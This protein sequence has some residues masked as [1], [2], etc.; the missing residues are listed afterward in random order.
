MTRQTN[1]FIGL[2]LVAAIAA[3][4]AVH[5]RTPM[6]LAGRV[7]DPVPVPVPPALP[8]ELTL[9]IVTWPGFALPYVA[10]E[11]NLFRNVTVNVRLLDDI[12]ARHAAFQSGEIDLMIGSVDGFTQEY[13]QGIHGAI[14]LVTDESAGADAILGNKAV[15]DVKALRGRRVAFARATP[16]HYL[17]YKSLTANGLTPADIRQFKVDDPTQAGQALL[18]GSV[19]AAATWEP[20]LSELVQSGKG[21]VLAS[22]KDYPGS[23]V[24]IVVASPSAQ[25]DEASLQAFV[26][27]WYRA[28]DF[29]ASN[30][31]EG[32]RI[33][34]SGLGLKP[35]EAQQLLLGLRLA[36]RSRN[37]YFMCSA[38]PPPIA[39]IIRDASDFWV[40]EGV[41]TASVPDA[42][43]MVSNISCPGR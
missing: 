11:K 15:A 18:S 37:Q 16:S 43:A 32:T 25:K 4:G 26:E 39:V 29:V 21:H 38:S 9:G 27:G 23:I 3:A 7:D 2:G 34:A 35:E 36:D 8:K 17:L 28:V 13:A 40:K 24:D 30:K 6:V 20:M 5:F 31:D 10:I 14:L 1:I 41:L 12:V 19:D 33:M 22:S 42:A